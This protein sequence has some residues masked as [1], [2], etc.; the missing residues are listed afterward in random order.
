MAGR[1]AGHH[2]RGHGY[3]EDERRGGPLPPA[4]RE[5]AHS[6]LR[7]PARTA[8]IGHRPVES[9]IEVRG[10]RSVLFW[11]DD[12]L[13]HALLLGHASI[14]TTELNHRNAGPRRQW[15]TVEPSR[16]WHRQR[17]RRT[18]FR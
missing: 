10:P 14:I 18:S 13:R 3:G 6:R 12:E 15:V 4:K 7:Q 5:P 1:F 17:A 16:I 11:R 8:A 2:D 9:F